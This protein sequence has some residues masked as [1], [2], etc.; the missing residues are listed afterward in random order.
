MVDLSYAIIDI[1]V[2]WSVDGRWFV[3]QVYATVE[4][5]SYFSRSFWMLEHYGTHLDAPIHFPPGKAT[6]DQIPAKQ[7]FGPAVVLDVSAEA[8]RDADYQ[9]PVSRVEEW[10]RLH[11]RIVEGSIGLL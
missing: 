11:G 9:M 7:F 8:G 2:P 6:V 5:N 1:L 3:A 4:K 10:E